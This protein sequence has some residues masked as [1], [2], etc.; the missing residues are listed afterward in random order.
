MFRVGIV[1]AHYLT[2]HQTHTISAVLVDKYP[3]KLTY[4]QLKFLET[5]GRM[6]FLLFLLWGVLSAVDLVSS[7][8]GSL[9]QDCPKRQLGHERLTK[10]TPC[11]VL[12]VH[13][14]WLLVQICERPC[15]LNPT[16]N[17]RFWQTYISFCSFEKFLTILLVSRDLW[18]LWRRW[19]RN[20]ENRII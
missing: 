14:T 6:V 8:D 17:L 12:A 2:Y 13:N 15:T 19:D 16:H 3:N 9:T 10:L 4:S 20:G 1:N 18:G 5:F 7:F 11:H